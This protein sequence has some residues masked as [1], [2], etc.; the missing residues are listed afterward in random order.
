[1]S[2]K[3]RWLILVVMAVMVT[4]GQFDKNA[5]SVAAVPISQE[6]GFSPTEM[7]LIISCFFITYTGM[8]LLGGFIADAYGAR[9]VAAVVTIFWSLFTGL[10]GFA[11]SLY[12]LLAIRFIFG[13]AEGA[14]PPTNSLIVAE[15]FPVEKRGFPKSFITGSSAL[16]IGAGAIAITYITHNFGWR[17]AFFFY[18]ILG[19]CFSALFYYVSKDMQRPV[20][21]VG[22]Q[23]QNVPFKEVFQVPLIWKILPIQFAGGAFMWGLNSWMPSYW[24]TVKGLKLTAMGFAAAIPMLVSA[25]FILFMG[26]ALDKYLAGKEK[27]VISFG[28]LIAGIF[29]YLAFVASSVTLGVVYMTVASI[30]ASLMV[31]TNLICVIKYFP[32]HTIGAGAGLGNGASQLAGIITPTL[33]GYIIT[34]SNGNYVAVFGTVIGILLIGGLIGMTIKTPKPNVKINAT[35]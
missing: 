32:Q 1:M 13:A 24:M 5:I 34:I 18:C 26:Y 14:F 21:T 12:S 16:G 4:L 10:T 17:N 23:K 6:F 22:T 8:N 19:F 3:R 11:W 35:N 7:G 9:R 28:A 31:Q 20:R 29:T 30:C 25:A 27:W 15:L 2:I 33:L